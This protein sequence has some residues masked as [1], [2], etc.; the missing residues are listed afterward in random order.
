MALIKVPYNNLIGVHLSDAKS[1][2]KYHKK[3]EPFLR[4]MAFKKFRKCA[5]VTLYAIS[6]FCKSRIA[7]LPCPLLLHYSKKIM[8]HCAPLPPSPPRHF[9][10]LIRARR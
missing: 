9:L 10:Q 8:A 7:S 5:N 6:F 1:C 3:V 2:T 4:S